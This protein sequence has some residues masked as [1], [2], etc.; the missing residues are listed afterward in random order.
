M[1]TKPHFEPVIPLG[2]AHFPPT[3]V[4]H[5]HLLPDHAGSVL[6]ARLCGRLTK[7]AATLRSAHPP[8]IPP[9]RSTA[10]S[11]RSF[12]EDSLPRALS[13]RVSRA[14]RGRSAPIRTA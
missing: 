10:R 9:C 11:R 3:F 13:L 4:T 5:T 12:S 1:L 7:P 6:A 14:G 2:S 8:E